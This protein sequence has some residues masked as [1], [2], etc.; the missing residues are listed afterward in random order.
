M[1]E[2][3]AEKRYGMGSG[4]PIA[5]QGWVASFIYLAIVLAAAFFFERSPWAAGSTIFTATAIFLVICAKTTR[6]GWHW[7]WGK[8]NER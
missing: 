3:F 4:L 8:E 7:R 2:W 1:A 6:G 5:W